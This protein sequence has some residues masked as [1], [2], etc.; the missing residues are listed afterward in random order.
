MVIKKLRCQLKLLFDLCK[1][2][3]INIKL[4]DLFVSM[5]ITCDNGGSYDI[6]ERSFDL[7]WLFF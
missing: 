3:N 7:E 5:L 4:I 1:L 6:L 2:N